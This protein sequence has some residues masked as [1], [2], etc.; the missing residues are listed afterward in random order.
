L[1]L[2]FIKEVKLIITITTAL[3]LFAFSQSHL[4]NQPSSAKVKED[5]NDPVADKNNFIDSKLLP[6]TTDEINCVNS[7]EKENSQQVLS[8]LRESI[9]TETK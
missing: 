6:L 9:V 2:G 4:S 8:L 3:F 7:S 5:S 1:I